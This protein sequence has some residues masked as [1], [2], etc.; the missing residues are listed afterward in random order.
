MWSSGRL[1]LQELLCQTAA[2]SGRSFS[3][4][5]AQNTVVVER[6]WKVNLAKK[7]RE[8]RLHPRRH[9]IYKVVEKIQQAPENK[10]ELMLTQTVP[11]IG[12]RGDTVVVKKSLGRNKLLPKGLAVYPSPENKEM[13]AEEL[14]R[15]REGRPEDR[16]QTRTGQL[17]VEL[18]KRSML[19]IMKMPTEDFQLTKEVVCRQFQK[20]LQIVVPLHALSLPFEPIK[21]LGDYWCDVTVNGIDTVRVP[22]TVL[23]YEDQSASNQK[24]L[25]RQRQEQEEANISETVVDDHDTDATGLKAATDAA[26]ET[27]TGKDT[28]SEVSA[29]AEK[30]APVAQTTQDHTATP[31]NGQK[32]H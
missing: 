19:N 20:K 18:L 21:E 27:E 12:G 5:P 8:P 4:T 11:K 1:V 17:T 32:K 15:L 9:R 24:K 16:I 2:V 22:M 13:F 10:M 31:G 3:R 30:V 23:P 7:D 28:E 25:K 26:T 6:M 14:R 29:S